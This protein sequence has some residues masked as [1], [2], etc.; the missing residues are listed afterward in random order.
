LAGFGCGAGVAPNSKVNAGA[1]GCEEIHSKG[2]L[3]E[4]TV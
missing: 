1:P 4:N 2:K 3:F